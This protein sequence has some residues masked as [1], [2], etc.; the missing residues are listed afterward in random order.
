[1]VDLIITSASF[2]KYLFRL[3]TVIYSLS[4]N[5]TWCSLRLLSLL[6]SLEIWPHV[7]SLSVAPVVLLCP[8]V[9]CTVTPL[10]SMPNTRT[11]PDSAGCLLCV[12][13][14]SLPNRAEPT[15]PRALINPAAAA[16]L[17]VHCSAHS[18]SRWVSTCWR[19]Q[20]LPHT[21]G[22]IAELAAGEQVGE[23]GEKNVS[24]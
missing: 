2:T 14:P 24:M 22:V 10:L 5:L 9:Y 19:H 6:S 16:A 12:P 8:A 23:T 21:G 13:P 17:C 15:Q 3:V 4:I 1:M 7:T 18:A 20:R 11:P